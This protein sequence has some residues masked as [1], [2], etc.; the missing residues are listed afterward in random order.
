MLVR[1]FKWPHAFHKHESERANAN[2]I[3]TDINVMEWARIC[4]SVILHLNG[5]PVCN[6]EEIREHV[7]NVG[8]YCCAEGGDLKSRPSNGEME[9]FFTIMD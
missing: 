7:D 1:L 6:C 3:E 8:I 9:T 5:A 4:C 2:G